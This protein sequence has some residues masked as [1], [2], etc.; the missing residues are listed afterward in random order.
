VDATTV[1]NVL[2]GALGIVSRFGKCSLVL[3]GGCL[4]LGPLVQASPRPQEASL[5]YCG[6]KKPGVTPEVFA[7]GVVSAE[8]RFERVTAFS[9]DGTELFF[10][11]TTPDWKPRIAYTKCED[12]HWSEPVTAS[13]SEQYDNTEPFMSPDGQRLYFASNRPPG[14]PPWNADIWMVERTPDGWSEPRHV[15]NVSSATLDYH[16]SVAENGNLY[17][18]STRDGDDGD[19]YRARMV[20]GQYQTPEKLGAA[21][22]TDS[23]EWDPYVTPDESLIIFKSDRPGGYGDMDMYVSFRNEDGSW[24]PAKNLGPPINTAEHDDAGDISPDGRFLF[25]A[26]RHGDEEMDIYWVDR[27]V[28]DALR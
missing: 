16:P 21:I 27:K 15:D 7:P 13:F 11:I 19:I 10:T 18:A 22:N 20:D 1:G 28:I 2:A 5:D 3:T 12:G 24:A 4:L 25:F 6:Q 26:R 14:S 23:Q 17:F 8:G 9:R